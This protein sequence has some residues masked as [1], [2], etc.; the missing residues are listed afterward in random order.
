MKSITVN[1]QSVFLLRPSKLEKL[2][3]FAP[4]CVVL[5]WSS[6]N[7]SNPIVPKSSPRG[8][9]R[10]YRPRGNTP[11]WP[12]RP[13]AEQ[14]SSRCPNTRNCSS[15]CSHSGCCLW[16][17]EDKHSKVYLQRQGRVSRTMSSF[18]SYGSSSP[19]TP[20]MDPELPVLLAAENHHHKSLSCFKA[21]PLVHED[22]SCTDYCPR[23]QGLPHMQGHG[24]HLRSARHHAWWF[25]ATSVTCQSKHRWLASGHDGL[26]LTVP[27]A[28]L[29]CFHSL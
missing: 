9:H 4:P 11:L 6:I 21:S 13:L 23:P 1:H 19:I 8:G 16:R 22:I 5:W 15:S 2:H 3:L 29:L 17:G 25:Q 20:N 28:S 10:D 14:Q 24:S 27:L 7:S 12:H 26:S 18:I